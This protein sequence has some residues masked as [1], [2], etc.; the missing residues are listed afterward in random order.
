MSQSSSTKNIKASQESQSSI[1]GSLFDGVDDDD[2]DYDYLIAYDDDS[3]DDSDG[4][5]GD[6]DGGDGGDGDGDG[7]DGTDGDVLSKVAIS[8]SLY[9][10]NIMMK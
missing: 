6:G 3:D 5:G 10:R 7:G 9:Q 1:I 2:D 4:D 8:Y